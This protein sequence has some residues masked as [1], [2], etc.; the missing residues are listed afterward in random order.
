MR[1][2]RAKQARRTLQFFE[3][4][5]GIRPPYHVLLDGTFVVT[6][7]KYKLPLRDRLDKLLQHAA[8]QLTVCAS[9]V[10]ELKA[11]QAAQTKDDAVFGEAIQWCR[12]HCEVM[13]DPA[14]AAAAGTP[15][16]DDTKT[17]SSSSSLSKAASDILRVAVNANT[18]TAND[19]AKNTN[20]GDH[21]HYK[22]RYFCATQD[23]EL[24]DQLRHH[25][26]PLI[27]LA[28]GS[29]LLLEQPS[30]VAEGADRRQERQKWKQAAS[31][32]EQKLVELVK[33][34]HQRQEHQ[35]RQSSSA[36]QQQQRQRHKGKAKGPNPLSCKKRAS[37]EKSKTESQRN[38]RRRK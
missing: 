3:R 21:H 8:F 18:T 26:V 24:L 16:S 22:K 23:E 10:V 9:T 19:T 30:K 2:G 28:R 33:Q 36:Q 25:P 37:T 31:E 38:K 11:L 14:G 27:R 32:P 6:V 12:E 20:N 1:H 29:V 17:P 5:A 35:Q 15:V 13:E 4:A 7:L 34:Q